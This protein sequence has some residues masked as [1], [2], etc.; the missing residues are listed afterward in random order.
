[1][2]NLETVIHQRDFQQIEIPNLTG[3]YQTEIASPLTKLADLQ[4]TAARLS[5]QVNQAVDATMN[6]VRYGDNTN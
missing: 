4:A 1:M 6:L 5:Q 2:A 3:E